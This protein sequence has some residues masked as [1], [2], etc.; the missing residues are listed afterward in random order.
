ME[1]LL[2]RK[3]VSD[4]SKIPFVRIKDYEYKIGVGEGDFLLENTKTCSLTALEVK[5][6]NLKRTGKTAR[7]KRNHQ[8]NKVKKQAWVYAKYVHK[9]YPHRKINVYIYTN[10][11]KYQKLGEILPNLK[12]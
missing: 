9:K 2:H 6:I 4:V 8:R 10:E 1:E 11:T 7:T 3:I 12:L 5:Y